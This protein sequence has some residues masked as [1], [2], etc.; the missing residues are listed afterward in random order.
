[1][2]RLYL[3]LFIGMLW[4]TCCKQKEVQK[5]NSELI[6]NESIK[7]SGGDKINTSTI[8]FTFRNKQFRAIRNKDSFQLERGFKDSINSIKDI[9]SNSGFKRFINDELIVLPDSIATKYSN[10]VNSV[11]YFSVLPYSLNDAAVNK[12]YLGLI[13]LKGKTYHKI[14]VTFDKDGGGDDFED[15]FVYWIN[16]TNY[17]VDYLAYSFHVNGGGMRFRKAYNERYIEGIRFVDYD[18]YKPINNDVLFLELDKLF[19]KDKLKLLS[20][21]K[22]ENI[23]VD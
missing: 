4:F 18:N 23:K 21:I 3:V 7:V 12:T 5:I 8:A 19:E 2:K 13:D 16:S 10:L 15:V 22:I 9:L 17:K 11:H 20:K 6:I 14:K 1:M